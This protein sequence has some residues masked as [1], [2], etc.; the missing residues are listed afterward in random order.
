MQAITTASRSRRLTSALATK[1]GCDQL[2]KCPSFLLFFIR[3]P[4]AGFFADSSC[5]HTYAS[6]CTSPNLKQASK[7]TKQNMPS[8]Y[9]MLN[10]FV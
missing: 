5:K 2:M 4:N 1:V 8:D 7:K 9:T 10:V 6:S 3:I